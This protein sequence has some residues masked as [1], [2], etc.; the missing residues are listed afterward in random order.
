[1]EKRRIIK[2]QAQC[3]RCADIIESKSVHNYVTCSCGNLSVDG[4]ECYL[5][6]NFK[7]GMDSWIDCSVYEEVPSYTLVAEEDNN[8][9]TL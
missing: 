7:E 3:L 9:K 4:G 1:M 5:K 6:R 2:N 8:G